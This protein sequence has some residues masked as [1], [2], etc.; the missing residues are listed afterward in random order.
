[1]VKYMTKFAILTIL[2]VQFSSISYNYSVVLPSPLFPKLLRH[3]KQ[4]LYPLS[5]SFSF[6]F[7]PVPGNL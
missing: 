3:H 1:M 2:G 7:P 6:L 5:N 4:K